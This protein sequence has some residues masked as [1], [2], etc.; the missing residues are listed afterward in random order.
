M[1]D[2]ENTSHARKRR[3]WGSAI[4]CKDVDGNPVS[5]QTR[6]V[7]PLDPSKK[8]GR[9]FGLE[10]EAEAYRWL[11]KGALPRRTPQQGHPSMDLPIATRCRHHTVPLDHAR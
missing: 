5:L 9:N 6:Y 7:N 2:P 8:V 11:G 3:E 10:Y 1:K 4:V